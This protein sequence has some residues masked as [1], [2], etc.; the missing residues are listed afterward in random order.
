V[1]AQARSLL[2]AVAMPLSPPS[3]ST[4]PKADESAPRLVDEKRTPLFGKLDAGAIALG[5]LLV[6]LVGVTL[7]IFWPYVAAIVLAAWGA[8]FARPL[9]RR[10]SGVLKGGERGAA[11]LTAGILVVLLLPIAIALATVI[12]AT[13]EAVEELRKSGSGR[14]WL[15][16]LVGGGGSTPSSGDIMKIVREYGPSASKV[17]ALVGGAS[18]QALVSAFVFLVVFYASLLNDPRFS[19]WLE[20]NAII[21]T[22]YVVRLRD[23]FFQAGRGLVIGNGL[24]A[25]AQGAIAMITFIA[26][27]VPRALVL[28]ILAI[29]AALVPMVGSAIIWIPVALGLLL[30]GHP[31]K[32][33]ILTAIG[34]GVISTIDNLLRPILSGRA[35]IGIDTTVVLVSMFG[36]IAI[37]GGWGLFLGPLIVRLA[38]EVLAIVRERR[39]AQRV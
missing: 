26:L 27:G 20:K 3:S 32:A 12:P 6:A 39:D 4:P 22:T 13:I 9:F 14:A 19:P 38:V 24:T 18:A 34:L 10:V 15:E 8:H 2:T 5:L 25:L 37:F 1:A 36:G 35:H 11:L 7:S 16:A 33:A 21:E 30:S 29:V 28:G 31:V 23:A 17:V